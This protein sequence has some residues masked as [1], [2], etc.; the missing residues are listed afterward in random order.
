M[1]RARE[2]RRQRAA[3]GGWLD[4]TARLIRDRDLPDRRDR[5]AAGPARD[6]PGL[7]RPPDRGGPPVDPVQ[8]AG[9]RRRTRRR[10]RPD[11]AVRA[12]SARRGPRGRAHG[13]ADRHAV[14]DRRTAG[15]PARPARRGP[16]RRLLPAR[17]V[18]RRGA[19]RCSTTSPPPLRGLGVDL[20]PTARPLTFG[21]WI[22]GDRDGNPYVTAAVTRDV[23]LIQ[24]EYGIRAA[25]AVVADLINE[26]SVSRR[27][28][29]VSLDLAVSLAKDLDAL[30]P[31]VDERFRR[32]NSEEVYRLKARCVLAKLANTRSRLAAGAPHRPGQDYHGADELVADLELMRTRWP[33]TSAQLA[34]HRRAGPGGQGHL[35]VRPPSGHNGHPRARRRPPRGPGRAVR[36][37][38]RGPRLPP[39]PTGPHVAADPRSWA[40]GGRCPARPRCSP[41]SRARRSTCSPRSASCRTGSARRPSSRTSSP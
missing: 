6:P 7:H 9:G 30:G 11:R 39:G 12:G 31:A 16:Q 37:G 28:R 23:L 41:R 17:P 36:T 20:P 24:H 15:D 27:L 25:E 10:G 4:Q 3:E 34:G 21:T 22:G 14:A 29:P 1:H 26:L 35:R 5:A 32:V 33:A 40:G 2:L 38:R 19:R 8:A 13:R 18:R